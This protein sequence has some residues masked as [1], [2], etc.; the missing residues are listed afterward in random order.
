VRI[1]DDMLKRARSCLENGWNTTIHVS[2]NPGIG[3]SRFY[4]YCIF[5]LLLERKFVS[6]Y[7]LVINFYDDYFLYDSVQ[8]EFIGLTAAEVKDLRENP[9]VFRLIEAGSNLLFGW[10][11]VSVL[12]AS[13]GVAGLNNFMKDDS[14][15]FYLPVW[16]FEEVKD[17]NSM[18]IPP[19]DENSLIERFYIFGG[20]P[21]F[22]FNDAQ[23]DEKG[24]LELAINSFDALKVL[25]YIKG[26]TVREKDYSHRVL[27]MVPSEDFRSILHLDFL[28]KHIAEKIIAKVTDDSIHEISSFVTSLGDDSGSTAVRGRIYEILCHR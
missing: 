24:E 14:Y 8:E 27:C 2:G 7:Q 19:L 28:S 9:K 23:V 15:R 3:K 10:S 1:Y 13:P 18:L 22:I 11:G 5:C 16:T 17:L 4:L 21:R 12:F 26:R 25:S 6:T 20:I